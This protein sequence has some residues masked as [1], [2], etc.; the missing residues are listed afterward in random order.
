MCICTVPCTL[1]RRGAGRRGTCCWPAVRCGP[2]VSVLDRRWLWF[3]CLSW[4]ARGPC[5]S[6]IYI[7]ALPRHTQDWHWW[8]AGWASRPDEIVSTGEPGR[9]RGTTSTLAR[10]ARSGGLH[11]PAVAQRPRWGESAVGRP[12]PPPPPCRTSST[13]PPNC[14]TRSTIRG[15]HRQNPQAVV[16][17]ELKSKWRPARVGKQYKHAR[18][19]GQPLHAN[20]TG[21]T[22]AATRLRG[23]AR[24]LGCVGFHV[25][26]AHASG[27]VRRPALRRRRPR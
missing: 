4:C 21:Q 23:A 5:T 27:L 13:R 17:R 25:Q 15:R 2:V 24:H 19:G 11:R 14:Q 7:H 26:E 3:L 9:P 8:S 12:S 20:L 18:D 6:H 22:P 1:C 10:A 16:A